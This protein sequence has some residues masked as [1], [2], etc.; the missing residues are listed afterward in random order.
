MELNAA[1]VAEALERLVAERRAL[2]PV[3]F[4]GER[5]LQ[6]FLNVY[7]NGAD[8]RTLQGL[9]TPLA[10]ADSVLVVGS[11]AGG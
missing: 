3:L 7:V 5:Q 2:A 9:A 8:I 6:P 10:D 11:V 1:S 4:A